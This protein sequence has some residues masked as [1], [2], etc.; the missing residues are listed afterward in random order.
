MEITSLEDED[1]G[2]WE[3]RYALVYQGFRITEETIRV[4]IEEKSRREDKP[5]HRRKRW[6]GARTVGVVLQVAN[7][8]FDAGMIGVSIADYAT[9]GAI[10]FPSID[11]AKR[12]VSTE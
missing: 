10:W 11:D 3:C 7:L 5:K 1:F 12:N 9:E 2:T 8:G 4:N 6:A